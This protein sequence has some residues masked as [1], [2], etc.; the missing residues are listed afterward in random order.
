MGKGNNS[1]SR[2]Q[3]RTPPPELNFPLAGIGASAGGL[4]AFEKFFPGIPAKR[5]QCVPSMQ[6]FEV[7]DG[8]AIKPNRVYIIPPNRD[9]AFPD[10]TP[11]LLQPPIPHGRRLPTDFFFRSPAPTVTHVGIRDVKTEGGM[12]MARQS[13]AR[14]MRPSDK[15]SLVSENNI[16]S[17]EPV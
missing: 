5:I 2:P 8:A 13:L 12:V 9:P 16:Q 3:G 6:A 17:T 14:R 7:E 11:H 1:Q 15:I 10:R 4:A